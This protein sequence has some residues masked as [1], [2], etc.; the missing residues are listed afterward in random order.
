[1]GDSAKVGFGDDY[2]KKH[3]TA[4]S[5]AYFRIETTPVDGG[6]EV[7]IFGRAGQ[8]IVDAEIDDSD[9]ALL[10]HL[11]NRA[12]PRKGQR[13]RLDGGRV[14]KVADMRW[15]AS[16]KLQLLDEDMHTWQPWR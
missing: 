13:V 5:N 14:I 2:S 3:R 4:V 11:R 15:D 16:G 6:A 12:I 7:R 9:T 10:L 1:M 8:R